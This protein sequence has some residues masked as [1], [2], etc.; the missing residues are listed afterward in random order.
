MSEICLLEVKIIHAEHVWRTRV[1]T[2]E[3][4]A[5]KKEIQAVVFGRGFQK[6]FGAA[7][8]LLC[9]CEK[10]LIVKYLKKDWMSSPESDVLLKFLCW[11]P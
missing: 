2:L 1:Q 9:P 5:K 8:E 11:V 6:P 3:I 7:D 4:Q 10:F